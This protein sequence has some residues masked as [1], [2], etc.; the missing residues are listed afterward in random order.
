LGDL[1]FDVKDSIATITLNRPKSLN[2]FSV[3]MIQHWIEALTEVRDN[4]DIR[5]LVLTGNGRAFCAGGDIK[6]VKNMEGFMNKDGHEHL[7]FSTTGL[8]RKNSLWKYIQR[9]P[10]LMEEIDKPTIA[11]INGD[12]I[13]AGFDMTLQCDIRIASSKARLGEGYVKLGLVPGDG[14]GYFL[15]RLIGVDKALELLWSGKILSAQEA[16]EI[17][18]VTH[19]VEHEK[20]LEETYSY[21]RKLAEGPQQAIRLTKRVVMQ[22]LK[23][24]LRTSLDQVSSLMGLVTEHPDYQEG[25]KALLEKR[26]PNFE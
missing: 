22:G 16:E 17:G 6:A 9:I 3:S 26:K 2:A 25:V 10:L 23:T 13:G 19:V 11:A 15:P 4:D 7:D 12:A 24:D 5:V 1:L 18:L 14:G 20:L 21:A 8:H